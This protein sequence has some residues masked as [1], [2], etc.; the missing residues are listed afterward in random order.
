M[1]P[2]SRSLLPSLTAVGAVLLLSAC[3]ERAPQRADGV[4]APAAQPS[5]TPDSRAAPGAMTPANPPPGDAVPAPTPPPLPPDP[6]SPPTPLPAD[7]TDPATPPIP[8]H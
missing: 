3:S 5:S 4:T 7:P 8:P 1:R 6:D 2:S